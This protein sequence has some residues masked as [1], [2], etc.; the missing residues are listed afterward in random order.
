M[1][2]QAAVARTCIT[3]PLDIP[4]GMWVAQHHVRAEGLD[5]DLFVRALA[6]ADGGLQVVLLDFDVCFLPDRISNAIRNEV[7]NAVGL[8]STSVLPFSSHTHAGPTVLDDYRGEGED[9][10]R[11]YIR[12]LPVWAAEAAKRASTSLAPARVDAGMGRCDIGMNRDLRLEDGRFVVGCNREGFADHDV[13]VIRLESTD[14]K[15]LACVVNYACHPTVLGPENRLISPDYPG[16]TRKIVEDVTGATCIFLQGAAGNMGP[17]ETFVAEA[18]VARRLGTILGLEASRV[19]LNLQPLP[20]R[21]VLR[22]VIA[23]GAALADYQ[24]IPVE[25]PEPRLE[26]VRACVELPVRT[27]FPEVYE[28]APER[29]AGWESRLEK[30]QQEG[31][32]HEQVAVAIQNVTRERLRSN[33]VQHYAKKRSVS[34]ESHVIRIGAAAIVTISGE[35]YCEVGVE[36]KGRSPFPGKTLVAGYVGGDMMYIPTAEAFD[37]VPPPMEVDNSPYGPTAARTTI[38]HMVSMLEKVRDRNQQASES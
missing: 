12:M 28:K 19:F 15:P 22:G 35:P 36:V 2:F 34:V 31:A 20:T 9:Q 37:Y 7:G 25:Q 26:F 11:E 10:I 29:L 1:A 8:P 24:Q 3:P 33:R 30:L 5:S 17:R 32:S 38:E 14:G 16:S 18:G 27:R 6:L 23:S 21:T 4:N 13:G